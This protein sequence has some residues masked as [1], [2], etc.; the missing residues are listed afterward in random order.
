M[1][2]QILSFKGE[3]LNLNLPRLSTSMGY[4]YVIW[5]INVKKILSEDCFIK[6]VIE[7]KVSQFTIK[8]VYNYV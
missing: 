3:A 5:K 6:F 4:L 7:Y 2:G 1:S 8:F